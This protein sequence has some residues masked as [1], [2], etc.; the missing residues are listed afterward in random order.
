MGREVGGSRE[1][2]GLRIADYGVWSTEKWYTY[3]SRA[4]VDSG[5]PIK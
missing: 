1:L 5:Y 4:K 3:K 2:K